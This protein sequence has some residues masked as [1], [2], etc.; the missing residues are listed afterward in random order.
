[1]QTLFSMNY[2]QEH[3]IQKPSAFIGGPEDVLTQITTPT[4][5]PQNPKKEQAGL[6]AGGELVPGE[7]LELKAKL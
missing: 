5:N 2:K 4:A 3:G 6:K 7:A 1:M